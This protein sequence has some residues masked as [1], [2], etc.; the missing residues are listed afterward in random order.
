[1]DGSI[2]RSDDRQAERK[3]IKQSTQHPSNTGRQRREATENS[4][5]VTVD[6]GLC[7]FYDVRW[8]AINPSQS[9]LPLARTEA[10]S[11][12]PRA[13]AQPAW[14]TAVGGCVNS[15]PHLAPAQIPYI[16][17]ISQLAIRSVS[18]VVSQS[19]GQLVIKSVASLT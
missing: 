3:T 19:I 15:W 2:D 13:A 14:A 18:Q 5:V 7:V 6:C 4:L 8:D 9:M 17:S 12:A 1:M 16:A 10:K 11:V